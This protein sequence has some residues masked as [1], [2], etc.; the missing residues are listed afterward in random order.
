[1]KIKITIFAN[2]KLIWRY[3][4]E[5]LEKSSK[6]ITLSKPLSLN[7]SAIDIPINGNVYD[8]KEDDE[9]WDDNIKQYQLINHIKDI[10]LDN[11]LKFWFIPT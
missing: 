5:C 11:L 6:Q 7:L 9:E 1:M 3:D 10:N 4:L 8:N 2:I